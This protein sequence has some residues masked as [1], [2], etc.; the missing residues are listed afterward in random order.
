MV[1]FSY[2]LISEK[3][4]I[5]KTLKKLDFLTKCPKGAVLLNLLSEKI[6]KGSQR[7]DRGIFRNVR[8]ARGRQRKLYKKGSILVS[9]LE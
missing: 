8:P 5:N 3:K 7:V 2:L 1:S 9:T 4:K 6:I